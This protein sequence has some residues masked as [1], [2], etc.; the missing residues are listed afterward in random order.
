M[1]MIDGL[2]AAK[3]I[4]LVTKIEAEFSG[5][6]PFIEAQYLESMRASDVTGSKART[7]LKRVVT[8]TVRSREDADKWQAAID[9]L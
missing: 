3:V 2:D 8:L 7:L 4:A 1:S 9:S 5:A 6:K